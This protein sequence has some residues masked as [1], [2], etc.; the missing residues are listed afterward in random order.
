MRTADLVEGAVYETDGSLM[1][2]QGRTVL[3]ARYT[4]E[5]KQ[6][7]PVFRTM[8]RMDTP[9]QDIKYVLD[10]GG[11]PWKA[12][13][14]EKVDRPI[15]AQGVH[16]MFAPSVPEALAKIEATAVANEHR[17]QAIASLRN[18]LASATGRAWQVNQP[19]SDE[20]SFSIMIPGSKVD[21]FIA[22]VQRRAQ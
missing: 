20:F 21:A 16:R 7:T 14:V 19:W 4:R 15:R 8:H 6:K 18:N 2:Y 17:K 1:V 11:R 9:V 5:Q 10:H 13:D 12:G 3:S 22:E